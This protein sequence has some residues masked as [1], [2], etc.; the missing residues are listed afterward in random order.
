MSGT[1]T[2]CGMSGVN[3][4]VSQK[5][6][7]LRSDRSY[8]CCQFQLTVALFSMVIIYRSLHCVSIDFH[9]YEKISLLWL[10]TSEPN[11]NISLSKA[12]IA[13]PPLR[14]LRVNKHHCKRVLIDFSRSENWSKKEWWC[15]VTNQDTTILN[16]WRSWCC[17][18]A[19]SCEPNYQ[20]VLHVTAFSL[21]LHVMAKGD[22]LLLD[23]ECS[24]V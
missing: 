22:Q 8:W 10:L 14:R 23:W 20:G 2:Y 1:Y 15:A 6:F 9:I 7:A 16:Y 4:E 13:N 17:P 12:T 19:L 11:L 21:T 5:P 3:L 18:M 24:W